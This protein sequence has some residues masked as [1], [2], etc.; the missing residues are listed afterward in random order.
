MNVAVDGKSVCN[1]KW[2]NKDCM[3]N[4]DLHDSIGILISYALSSKTAT[5]YSGKLTKLISKT[6]TD[7]IEN[8][9]IKR[10]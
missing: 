4:T 8:E 9:I 6:I 10:G 5:H 1:I 2:D 3:G 7:R